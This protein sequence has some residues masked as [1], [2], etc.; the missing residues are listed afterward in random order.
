M[1][2]GQNRFYFF[3][4]LPAKGQNPELFFK[5][6]GQRTTYL[7]VLSFDPKLVKYITAFFL[8]GEISPKCEIQNLLDFGCLKFSRGERYFFKSQ[9]F[10]KKISVCSQKHRRMIIFF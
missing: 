1:I 9:K 4:N 3:D 10:Y 7:P 8:I 2:E 6:C 5:I